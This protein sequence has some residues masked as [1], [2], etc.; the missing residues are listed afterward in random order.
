MNHAVEYFTMNKLSAEVRQFV[1][2]FPPLP[3]LFNTEGSGGGEELPR[4]VYVLLGCGAV[5]LDYWCPTFRYTML[6]SSSRIKC[7]L[8]VSSF[9]I[10]PFKFRPAT[11]L[12]TSGTSLPA[13]RR[14]I[15]KNGDLNCA[16][17]KA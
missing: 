16:T 7:P 14:H 1:R 12:E 6:V 8:K 13:T 4:G 2:Y 15:K 5:S 11:Y 3:H 17:V 10:L 9:D